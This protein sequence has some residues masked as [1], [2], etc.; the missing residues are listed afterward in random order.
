M[1]FGGDAA[2]APRTSSGPWS[3]PPGGAV[4]PPPLPRR[5]RDRAAG[6]RHEAVEPQDGH[7]RV[8]YKNDYAP[9]ERRL[10]PHVVAQGALQE[11][12]HRSGAGF[13][14]A[15]GG[16]GSGALPEL[17]HPD[18]VRGQAVHRVRCLHRHLPGRLPDHHPQGEEADLRARLRAP[19]TEPTQ[20]LY[21]SAALTQTARVMV[22]DENLC[23]HCGLCA[24]RCPTAAWDM[25]KSTIHWPH[26]ADGGPRMPGR[27]AQDRV[28]D[29]VVKIGHRQRYRLGQCQRP[30][31]EGHLQERCAGGGEE[32]FPVQHPG[33]ADLVR[34][35]GHARRPSRPRRRLPTS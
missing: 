16:A 22:K 2:A 7:A 32:L 18:G 35:P 34:D 33:A 23:V 6:Q 3:R 24:E 15:A 28:N 8:A 9:L 5:S 17:R 12:Q 1:F 13:H 14:A 26:A 27:K 20:P 29:F 19:P 11:A 31:D 4:D 25:Q 21:V 30:A 10:M